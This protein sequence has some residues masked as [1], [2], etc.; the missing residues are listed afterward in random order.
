[1]KASKKMMFRRKLVCAAVISCFT[2]MPAF[3]NPTGATVVNGQVGFATQGNT[4]TITNSPNAIINWQQFS[5]GAGETTRFVQQN[6]SSAVLNRVVGQ[7]PSQLLGSLLSNGRVYLINPNGILFGQ[8][9]VIDVGGLV[10]STLKLS[11]GDFLAGRLNFTDG[12]GAGS[13]NN[14]GSITT[15]TGGNVYL[16]APDISN[17]G[18]ITSP[19]GE[20]LLA[21]GHSVNLMDSANP[22]VQVMVGASDTQA[23]NIGSL[24]ARSGKIGIYGALIDQ[25]GMVNADTAVVSAG[26]K[27]TLKA[28]KDITLEPGSATTASGESGGVKE[29]GEI[30]IVADGML[31]VRQGSEIHVDGGVDGGNGGFLELS[32]KQAI[33]LRGIYTG[34]AR[35]AGYHGGTLLLDPTDIILCNNYTEC[36]S[37]DITI[38]TLGISGIGVSG[39][40]AD[41]DPPSTLYLHTNMADG[42]WTNVQL[43]ATHDISVKSALTNTDVPAGGSLTL[44]A[45]NDINVSANIGTSTADRFNHDLTMVA[46]NNVNI[47]ASI[48][49]GN[50]DLVV[51]A[52]ATEGQLGFLPYSCSTSCSHSVF[53]KPLTPNPVTVDV[54]GGVA[55]YAP[56]DGAVEIRGGNA[57]NNQDASVKVHGGTVSVNAGSVSILG[58]TANASATEGGSATAAASAELSA[59]T[60]LDITTTGGGLTVQ[61]G[62][63][64]AFAASGAS[65]NATANAKLH[66]NAVTITTNGVEVKG[67]DL[68]CVECSVGA[69]ASGN[70][71]KANALANA[72]LSA[73]GGLTINAGGDVIVAGGSGGSNILA[74]ATN[75]GAARTELKALLKGATVEITASAIDTTASVKVLGGGNSS[76]WTGGAQAGNHGVATLDASAE[77]SADTTLSITADGE[78]KVQGGDIFAKTNW[79]VN[80]SA[81]AAANATLKSG[82]DMTL[83]LTTGVTVQGGISLADAHLGGSHGKATTNANALVSA[84]GK[85]NLTVRTGGLFVEG[86][87]SVGAYADGKPNQTAIASANATIE[88]LG[89]AGMKL[90]VASGI[91]V[92]GYNNAFAFASCNSVEMCSPGKPNVA[93][94][95]ANA[96]ISTPNGLLDITIHGGGL[97]VQGGSSV[98]ASAGSHG[99]NEASANATAS[100]TAKSMQLDVVGGVTVS[101]GDNTYASAFSGTA[102]AVNT[103]K[104]DA[105]AQIKS[106]DA[107]TLTV[108]S[109]NVQGGNA[110]GAY[111]KTSG[112]NNAEVTTNALIDA[113]SLK[114]DTAGS[115]QVSGGTAYALVGSCS[116]NR[117]N[118]QANATIQA[119]GNMEVTNGLSGGVSSVTIRAGRAIAYASSGSITNTHTSSDA[120]ASA[121][122]TMSAGSLILRADGL[123]IG[124]GNAHA[125]AG[126]DYHY[127]YSGSFS[128]HGMAINRIVNAEAKAS[129]DVGTVSE[130]AVGSGGLLIEGSGCHGCTAIVNGAGGINSATTDRSAFL[131][132]AGNI[133]SFTVGG[134]GI[135]IYGGSDAKASAGGAGKNTAT[136]NANAGIRVGGSILSGT[137]A[138][139][140]MGSGGGSGG[141]AIANTSGDGVNTA[142][143]TAN[144]LITVGGGMTLDI[145]G[146]MHLYG[147]NATVSGSGAT[148]QAVALIEGGTSQPGTMHIDV[149]GNVFIT[150]GTGG[151]SNGPGAL[152]FAG[153]VNS[154]PINMTIYNESGLTLEGG[155]GGA[156]YG[157]W[158]VPNTGL[159]QDPTGAIT[160][161][162]GYSYVIDPNIT[163]NSAWD[164]AFIMT[165]SSVL[166]DAVQYALDRGADWVNG[167][168]PPSGFIDPFRFGI[169]E[170]NTND[171]PVCN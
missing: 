70:G 30:R 89:A 6:A 122:A 18:V 110:A 124:G 156:T 151:N 169:N 25:Q 139:L 98:Q 39:V 80:G 162:N 130:L 144:T 46:G 64:K 145:S 167:A 36:G 51:R 74:Y 27:I 123:T 125:Q 113:G 26:G 104:A 157:S 149:G 155:D 90:D 92:H 97:T 52:G 56:N 60:T 105:S 84:G 143:A 116:G 91:T 81:V 32:G 65:A 152:A 49:M 103:A 102:A 137:I 163:P 140:W 54:L 34:A 1:M 121:N 146:D 96:S 59:D 148:A 29:G 11:N 76:A 19:Q 13:I 24:I 33:S 72:E 31:N 114:I 14:Q 115:I 82:G 61:A 168:A 101:G 21:A 117:V 159:S 79:D 16:I 69:S 88:A 118:A 161:T 109:L 43:A 138:S 150:G 154:G 142:T 129:M 160:I 86:G 47:N 94:T 17:S 99:K 4:L 166:P 132:V 73:S 48:Y 35:A 165:R 45:G 120:K 128:F 78:L 2:A 66:G 111:I 40:V 10:A 100:V 108:D 75:G 38:S 158:T 53:I 126:G 93:T 83:D 136:E 127:P 3:A 20:I 170:D 68:S 141:N 85:L 171:K 41:S 87:S 134:S 135:M 8:G 119:T 164:S 131:H 71:S 28:S 42:G 50:H 23:V 107:M 9:A 67:G 58:G 62:Q 147:G 55:L 15:P 63:V 77:L 5:I 153:I 22:D 7:D 95:N 112:S 106:T 37:S 44:A 12:L 57:G 133:S